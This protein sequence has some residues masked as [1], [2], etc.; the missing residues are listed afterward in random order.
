MPKLFI[1]PREGDQSILNLGKE[2]VSIGR[3]PDSAITV[4]EQFCSSHHA[5]IYPVEGGCA[6]LDNHSKNGTFVNG[7]RIQTETVLKKGDEILIGLTRIVFDRELVTSVE[8]VEPPPYEAINTIIQVKEILKKSQLSTTLDSPSLALDLD[9][10]K[11]EHRAFIILNEVSQALVYHQPLDQLLEHVMDLISQNLPMDRGVL[12]LMEG[13]PAQLIPKAIRIKDKRLSDKNI[14]VSKTI[15]NT[16]LSKNSS[17]LIHDARAD[18]QFRSQDSIV[19]FNIRSALCVPL[20]NN[21]EITGIIYADRTSLAAPFSEDDLKLLTLMANLAA[22]KIEN[23]KLIEQAIDKVRMEKELALAT[24]IQKN[25]LPKETPQFKDFDIV[26]ANLTCYEVGGDYYDFIPVDSGRLGIVIADVSGKGMSASLLMA[27]LRAAL[28]S[29][30]HA[31]YDLADMAAKLNNF[32]HRSSSTDRFITFFFGE[33]CQSSGQLNYINAGHNSPLIFGREGK[34]ER[35][36][37]DGFCLGMFPAVRYEKRQVVLTPGDIAVF[38]TDGIT[39]SRNKEKEEFDE[40]RLI[41]VV[42]K[43][44]ERSAK[45]LMEAIFENLKLFTACAE[46]T[47]DMTVVIMK[48]IS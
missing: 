12:M 11:A 25:F 8:V 4:A 23:A 9:K 29:E 17:V 31:K 36:E 13:N 15:L 1:Y 45:E 16:V 7:K 39:E 37:S 24:Q 2:R 19:Q 14:Q 3:S 21:Q 46:P 47:D 6:V 33:L 10:L 32:V 43:N 22:V 18:T 42:Q 30:V 5:F 34:I 38:Y 40:R 27:S 41:E 20:W 48:R 44:S 28:H 35:L 26:G